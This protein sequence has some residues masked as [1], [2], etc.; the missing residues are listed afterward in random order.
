MSTVPMAGPHPTRQA[1][2]NNIQYYHN[3]LAITR[4]VGRLH[5]ARKSSRIQTPTDTAVQHG[6]LQYNTTQNKST[7]NV[8]SRI[9]KRHK[10]Y[11]KQRGCGPR[12]LTIRD[13]WAPWTHLPTQYSTIKLTLPCTLHP[14]YQVA[15]R[16]VKYKDQ[17]PKTHN[18]KTWKR[19]LMLSCLQLQY[20]TE[21]QG[22]AT[23][24]KKE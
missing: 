23:T 7:Q 16:T 5:T 21:R 14:I 22:K 24:P 12:S 6:T 15:Y 11:S 13:G 4:L 1:H 8:I 2:G 18:T 10:Q 17:A 19:W 9:R 3:D 20:R